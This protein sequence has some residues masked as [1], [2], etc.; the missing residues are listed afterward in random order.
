MKK[1]AMWFLLPVLCVLSLSSCGGSEASTSS[2][3]LD[4]PASFTFDFNT[5]SYS[6]Q[7][8]PNATFYS[9]KVYQYVDGVLDSHAVASSGMIKASEENA[10]YSGTMEEKFIAGSYRAVIKAIAPRYKTGQAQV[11]G[12]S[13][14][15][16]APEVSASFNDPNQQGGFPGPG[17]MALAE[18]DT[19]AEEEE[20]VT[21]DITITATDT[22]TKDYTLLLT[23]TVNDKVVYRNEGVVAGEL[24]L[25]AEDLTDVLELSTED[26]Y[27]V[28]VQGNAVEGYKQ[29]EATI[30][31]VSAPM[32]GGFPPF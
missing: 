15:L 28:S 31:T 7:G 12:T 8:S 19:P 5:S 9:L 23:D 14:M 2:A 17:P 13:E 22:I 18:G 20:G 6:F 27:E 29:A 10:D 3:T 4:A 16:G 25:K 26:S 21:I 32:G 11:E 1:K 30:V 24:N